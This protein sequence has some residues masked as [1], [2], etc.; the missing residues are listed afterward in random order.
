LLS[1]GASALTSGVVFVLQDGVLTVTGTAAADRISVAPG[2]GRLVLTT[3]GA[4]QSFVPWQIRRVIVY[5]GD[6]NDSV[7][8]AKGVPDAVLD[9]GAGNDSLLGGAARDT[10]RGGEGKDDIRGG[11]GNDLLDGGLRADRISG[12]KGTDTV[13]YSSR[14]VAVRVSLDSKWD[15]GQAGE[16]DDVETD[17]ENVIGTPG[18]DVLIGNAYNNQLVGLAGNDRLIGGSGNDAVLG[19]AGNDTLDGGVGNDTVDGGEGRDSMTG[20]EG[21]DRIDGESGDDS[22]WGGLGADTLAGG[23]GSDQLWGDG[24]NDLLDGGVPRNVVYADNTGNDSVYGSDGNDT[25]SAPDN[26]TGYLSG[27]SGNDT[28][29]GYA[30]NDT[31]YGGE[32]NDSVSAGRGN[33]LVYAEGGNDIINGDDGNDTVNAGAGEDVLRGNAGDDRLYGEEGDDKI[34]GDAGADA[35]WGG[36]GNDTLVSIGGGQ[37]D[38]MRGDTGYDSFWA[39]SEATEKVL[40]ADVGEILKGH[41]HRVG[42]FMS[43]RFASVVNPVGRDPNGENLMDPATEW[44]YSYFSNR[45]LFSTGGPNID[46]IDQNGLGDCY[47]LAGLGAVAKANPDRIRQHIVELGDG[48]FGVQFSNTYIRLDGDLPTDTFGSPVY[49][50]L[51]TG[52]VLWAAL[53]EKAFAY[54]RFNDSNYAS[55]NGGWMSEAFD[56]MGASTTVSR[57][58]DGWYKASHG[59][60]DLWNYVNGELAAGKA[61]TVS[62]P[63]DCPNLVGSHAYTVDRAWTDGS[64]TRHVVVRNPWGPDNTDGNPYVDL[65]ASQLYDSILVVQSAVV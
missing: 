46:D 2:G 25:L 27:G 26:G 52:G 57:W 19:G 59:A 53:M 51:G 45:P 8:L 28:F 11:D 12:G 54:Y 50:G 4:Q 56:A 37:N 49:A 1:A 29:F 24:G 15:D 58:V 16:L 7:T 33:D 13:D 31:V 35:M 38:A 65:T 20:G 62:T 10:L 32:G 30:G 34:Y 47:F 40:D 61:V 6:G 22:M 39:D 42:S 5:A 55:L 18:N 44:G 36:D 17:V 3:N 41:V 43:Y 60:T 63:G 48:T 9:G 14:S 64:G 21:F 23:G